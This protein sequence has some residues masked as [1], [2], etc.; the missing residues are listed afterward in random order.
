MNDRR[1]NSSNSLFLHFL[2]AH[3]HLKLGGSV[4]VNDEVNVVVDKNLFGVHVVNVVH[5]ADR[6]R[7]GGL[8]DRT[9]DGEAHAVV[10][11]ALGRRRPFLCAETRGRRDITVVSER[12]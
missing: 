11:L 4:V 12:K 6:H 3:T 8:A 5:C 2:V 1:S 10:R 7:V 9:T